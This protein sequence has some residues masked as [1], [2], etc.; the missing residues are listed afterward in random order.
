MI[1]LKAIRFKQPSS[2]ELEMFPFTVPV[3]AGLAGSE[4]AFTSPVT[5]LIG[6][7]GSG[8]STVL[9]ALA[10]AIGSIAVGSDSIDRDASLKHTQRLADTMKIIWQ[11]RTLPA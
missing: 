7:N 2:A 4:I 3:V 1:H 11:Q 10:C 9:E 8:K 5:F 6:E